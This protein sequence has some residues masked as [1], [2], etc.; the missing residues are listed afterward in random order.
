MLSKSPLLGDLS[1]PQQSYSQDS[2]AFT[3]ENPPRVLPGKGSE[4]TGS[5][6]AG[7]GYRLAQKP[8]GRMHLLQGLKAKW[9]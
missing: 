7:E 4:S 9:L 1:C 2:A 3:P 8:H 6:L 5:L